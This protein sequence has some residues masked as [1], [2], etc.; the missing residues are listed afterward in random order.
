LALIWREEI[1]LNWGK[2]WNPLTK[3]LRNS[4]SVGK[5]ELPDKKER[6]RV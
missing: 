4:K 6:K 5:H 3:E 1:L 2:Y